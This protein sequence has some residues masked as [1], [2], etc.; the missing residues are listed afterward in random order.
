[1][2]IDLANIAMIF[3]GKNINLQNASYRI[4]WIVKTELLKVKILFYK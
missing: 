2:D 3:V 1:M 4:K